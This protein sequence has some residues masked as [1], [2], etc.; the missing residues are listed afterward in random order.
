MW[1]TRR[2]S[3]KLYELLT[4][5]EYLS[6]SPFCC[7]VRVIR[8]FTT[9]SCVRRLYRSLHLAPPPQI[10]CWLSLCTTTLF[11]LAIRFTDYF[12]QILWGISCWC[13]ALIALCMAKFSYSIFISRKEHN[14]FYALFLP[15]VGRESILEVLQYKRVLFE[16]FTVLLWGSCY[17]IFHNQVMCETLVSLF[18]RVCTAALPGS[19]HALLREETMHK[20]NNFSSFFP[21]FE[22]RTVVRC[23]II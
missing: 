4:L 1:V 15:V 13:G 23:T 5:P 22:I 16:F 14:S 11:Q 6:S 2:V 8:S 9:R 18:A 21:T 19:T 17:S 3:Y 7:G 20:M 12:E 10:W